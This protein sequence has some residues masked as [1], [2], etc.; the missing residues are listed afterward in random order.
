MIIPVFLPHLGCRDRCIY[1]DQNIITDIRGDDLKN[2]IARAL[3]KHRGPFEVGLY[4]GNIFNIIP[5]ELYRLFSFFESYRGSITNFAISTKPVPLDDEVIS[6]L[7]ENKVTTIELGIPSFN[8][9]IL[10]TLKRKHTREDLYKAF[11]RLTY[12]GFRVALQVMVGLP[13]ETMADIRETV[14]YIISLRPSFI[15]IY[16]LAFIRG[17]PLADMFRDESFTPI[18]FEDAVYRAMFIY[19]SALRHNIKTVKMGL[20][21]NEVIKERIVGGYYHPAFGF[22]V[23]SEAFFRALSAKIAES[24]LSGEITVYLNDRDTSHLLGHKRINISRFHGA[25]ITIARVASDVP[26]GSFIVKSDTSEIKGTIFDAIPRE[27]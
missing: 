21:D 14:D 22:L 26:P 23:K 7:K 24:G 15:R 6:I 2:R 25:G 12:D 27:I 19:I 4:G 5:E 16:P 17:T 3:E 11:Q 20:T 8:N 9:T 18:P 13:H 10:E 1:C